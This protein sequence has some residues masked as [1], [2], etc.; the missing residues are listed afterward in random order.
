MENQKPVGLDTY[1]TEVNYALADG[2]GLFLR[3]ARQQLAEQ[4]LS[5]ADLAKVS[6]LDA[7]VIS[8]V[9]IL[10][11]DIADYL[12]DDAEGSLKDWWWH[13]GKISTKR[14]PVALLPDY[15]QSVYTETEA[16]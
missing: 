2:E 9:I 6:A 4:D 1:E 11:D 3:A 7:V 16:A 15:L 8:S 12:V 5:T 10:G 14:Y 13:L